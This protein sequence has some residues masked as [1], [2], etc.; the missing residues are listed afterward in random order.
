MVLLWSSLLLAIQFSPSDDCI[1]DGILGSDRQAIG[2]A[3]LAKD[4]AAAADL[5]RPAT[6]RCAREHR[7]STQQALQMNG[8]AAMRFAADA[9]AGKFGRPGWSSSALHTI[10]EWPLDRVRT[11]A[12]TGTDTDNA[13]FKLVLSRMIERDRTLPDAVKAMDKADLESFVLIIKLNA[14][15]ELVRRGG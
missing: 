8:Y 6:D 4:T 9:L 12:S 5:T 10:R 11:L 15:A 13:A 7:W 14:V 1:Y 3:V 2:Q